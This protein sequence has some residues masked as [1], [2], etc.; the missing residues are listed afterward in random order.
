MYSYKKFWDYID[1]IGLNWYKLEH[2]YGVNPNTLSRL[3]NN[4]E[5]K[6]STLNKLCVMLQCQ[7][8]DIVEYI[9]DEE[10]TKKLLKNGEI[11]KVYR[12]DKY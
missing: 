3:K 5:V 9:P 6:I 1:S 10:E 11:K 12:G 8:G 7:F 2:H 4:D